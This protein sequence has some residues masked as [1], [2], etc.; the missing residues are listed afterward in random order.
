M[1]LTH[2][3]HPNYLQSLFTRIRYNEIG[4]LEKK[5]I[6]SD[7]SHVFELDFMH[8]LFQMKLY[9]THQKHPNYLQS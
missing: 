9:L 1:Y 7:A 4:T 5:H 8:I 2:Q 3:K 6:N